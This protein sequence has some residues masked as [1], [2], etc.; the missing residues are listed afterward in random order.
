MSRAQIAAEAAR[1]G[2]RQLLRLSL[3]PLDAQFG[4]VIAHWQRLIT[5]ALTTR[6]AVTKHQAMTVAEPPRYADMLTDLGGKL[7]GT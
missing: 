2:N 3:H 7:S 5:T 6:R 4:A 1:R